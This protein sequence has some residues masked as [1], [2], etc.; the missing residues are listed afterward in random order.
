MTYQPRKY[1]TLMQSGR[2]NSF[3][4]SYRQS[5]LWIGMNALEITEEIQQFTLTEL[6]T[7][8][9]NL[10]NYIC[11][12]PDFQASLIPINIPDNAP[13]YIKKM[14]KVGNRAGIGPLSAIAGFTAA[15]V[16]KKLN[17]K[18]HPAEIVVE[19]GGDIY[20]DIEQD[21]ALTIHA[22]KSPLSEKVSITIPA[23]E[24]P[25]G[26]C[27]SSGKIGPSLS[28]GNAD[29]VMIACKN[30]AQADAFATA[31]G[32][33]VKS[34]QDINSVLEETEN[35]SDILSAII[36]CDDKIGIR[37]KFEITPL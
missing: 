25:L 13:A 17:Q 9:Q 27:T 8:W 2:F 20:L 11:H 18:F 19:N 14:I 31:F 35:F 5:D 22:G 7:L 4:V 1:R 26:V 30:T 23:T 33:K 12:Y 37:G 16:G 10:E 28:S 32:N 29:A 34:I 24:S 36:I 6:K 15:Y 3:L 21:I